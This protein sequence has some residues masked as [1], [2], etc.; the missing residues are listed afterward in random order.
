MN[1]LEQQKERNK[2]VL[3]QRKVIKRDLTPAL[4][5]VLKEHVQYN[6][7]CFQRAEAGEN[8]ALNAALRDGAHELIKWL[9]HELSTITPTNDAKPTDN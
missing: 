4:L 2:E 3:R 7:P 6:L 5:S 9:E 1:L 8:W